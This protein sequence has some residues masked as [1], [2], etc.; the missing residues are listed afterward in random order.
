MSLTVP[1]SS[2]CREFTGSPLGDA[3]VGP[4]PCHSPRPSV[5]HYQCNPEHGQWAAVT[6]V[7]FSLST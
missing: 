2:S 4:I 6:Y 5:G 3:C 7:L 1:Q